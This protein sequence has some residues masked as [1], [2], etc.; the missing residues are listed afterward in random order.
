MREP[1]TGRAY[2]TPDDLSVSLLLPELLDGA[3][4]G[5]IVY[6]TDQG[7]PVAAV[8]PID[9]AEAGLAALGRV[10]EQ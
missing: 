1:R 10:E 7:E 2:A 4:Q 5:R 9:V 3:N 8:V 6:L